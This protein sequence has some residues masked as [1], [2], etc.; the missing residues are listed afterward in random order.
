MFFC[1]IGKDLAKAVNTNNLANY[2]DEK[3]HKNIYSGKNEFNQ[4]SR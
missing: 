1:C 3:K 4:V 2:L